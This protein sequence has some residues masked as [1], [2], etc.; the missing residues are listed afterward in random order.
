[1][2]HYKAP[3]QNIH[4]ILFDTFG[5]DQ[6]WASW[7]D[8]LPDRDLAESILEEA[9][10]ICQN[11]LLPL[12]QSG[13]AQGCRF[14]NG[15]VTTPDGFSEAFR[16]YAASGWCGL[17]GNPEYGGQNLPK[18]LT[19][20]VDEMLY[21]ANPSFALYSV[22]SS[23]ASL[24]IDCHASESL[25][26]QYLPAL[27]E[28]RWTGTMCLTEAQAGSDLGAIITRAEP[29]DNDQYK[30]SGNK[31]FITGGEHDL[32]DNIIHLVLARLPGAPAG[33]KGISLF[34]VPKFV[35]GDDGNPDQRN[36]VQCI[37]I[38]SKMGI[39]AS[40]TCQLQ[41][42]D[43][44]GYLVGTP[45][46]GLNH[47]FTMMNEERLS[48]ATQG[49]GIAE[50]GYQSSL[51]YAQERV[52]SQVAPGSASDT[53]I[54][55]PDV[56]RM[57]QT[58]QALNGAGRA[59]AA[60][61]GN[62]VDISRFSHDAIEKED[63]GK[64]VALLTPVAKSF[65]TDNGIDCAVLAQQIF[66]GHGYIRETGVEQLV[67]DAR[68]AQIYEGTNGI[69]ALDLISRKVLGDK[70]AG[71]QKLHKEIDEFIQSKKETQELNTIAVAAGQ[72]LVE[73]DDTTRWIA[74]HNSKNQTLAGAVA[75]EY[76]QLFG[77]TIYSYFWLRLADSSDD[78]DK[79][80]T[81]ETATFFIKHLLPHSH[82]FA[83]SIQSEA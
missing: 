10:K 47:M 39:K 14:D 63:A 9:A 19:L 4:S 42:D 78:V 26:Q 37:G 22:L 34:L 31:I 76:L 74:E 72:A 70:L 11:L 55:H 61:I 29:A 59:L 43:A 41:F 23:G 48:I 12:N 53:I 49:L 58:Q 80:S 62:Q 64:M 20:M 44:T 25:K 36:G 2:I 1:M 33:S 54:E 83:H 60:Y 30:I 77:L 69:Q 45:G 16:T 50:T 17:G 7:G 28:G 66:G 3:L 5:L 15:T 27:Y 46:R 65:L 71:Y 8:E 79:T 40:S 57:L 67:R 52:Q 13:D 82:A 21:A 68:I 18:S 81:L 75:S 56:K 51:A 6:Q 38:E 73:L 35:L 32:S 24:L